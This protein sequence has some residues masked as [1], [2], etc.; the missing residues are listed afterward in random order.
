M[1]KKIV[2]TQSA[3]TFQVEILFQLTR[4]QELRPVLGNL[5]PYS[6]TLKL[7]CTRLCTQVPEYRRQNNTPRICFF[8]SK[9]S[10]L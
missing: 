2:H 8:D 4:T 1:S 3:Y 9:N 7:T 6:G 10:Y 5:D